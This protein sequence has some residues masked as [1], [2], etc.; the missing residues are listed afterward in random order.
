[1]SYG[2]EPLTAL[3]WN[4]PFGRSEQGSLTFENNPS[5]RNYLVFFAYV[6]NVN[7]NKLLLT[8]VVVVVVVLGQKETRSPFP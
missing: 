7:E 6:P 5:V 8:F 3:L 2:S 4:Q 1:M